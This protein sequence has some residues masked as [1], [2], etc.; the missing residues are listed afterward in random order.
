MTLLKRITMK[1][2]MMTKMI[3]FL[4]RMKTLMK[5]TPWMMITKAM[6]HLMKKK[7]MMKALIASQ[8]EVMMMTLAKTKS[9]STISVIVRKVSTLI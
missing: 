5:M 8:M 6:K 4:L 3:A 9:L 7:N 2:M 1:I